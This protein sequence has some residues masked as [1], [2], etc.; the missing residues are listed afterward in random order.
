METVPLFLIGKSFG[1]TLAFNLALRYPQ[2]FKGIGLVAPFFQHR[3]DTID[4]YQYVLKFCNIFQLYYSFH[5]KDYPEQYK[6]IGQDPKIVHEAK[7]STLVTFYDEQQYSRKHASKQTTPF[8][9]INATE[10]TTV[11]NST[12]KAI[13]DL[14]RNPANKVVDLKGADHTSITYDPSY[15]Q[16]VMSSA[17]DYFDTLI[18]S[19]VAKSGAGD[20]LFE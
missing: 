15:A 12:N 18:P 1:G 2:L 5:M 14:V 20:D 16:Q 3:D 19:S 6:Y 17:A 11:R 10:D 8:I 9:M 13:A 7:I 4:K